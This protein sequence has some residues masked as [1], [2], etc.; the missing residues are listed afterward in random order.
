MPSLSQ[1]LRRLLPWGSRGDAPVV[2]VVRLAGAIGV[3]VGFRPGLSLAAA[4][5]ALE[6]A[7]SWPGAKAVALLINSPGGSPTQS[8]LIHKRIRVLAD[9]KKLPVHAFVEDAA[10]S[11]GYMI[12]CAADDIHADPNSI[13]GS[14]GVVS[15]GFGFHELIARYGIERRLY[16]T[17]EYKAL[18]DPFKPER[19]EDVA[20]LREIQAR[21]FESFKDLVRARRGERLPEEDGDLFT[22][23][24]WAGEDALRMGLV[25][26]IGEA[27]GVLRAKYGEG[28]RPRLVQTVRPGLVAR[29]LRRGGPSME[30]SAAGLL[31]GGSAGLLDPTELMAALEERAL[32]SRLGL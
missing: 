2:P 13:V 4:A 25:D 30:M 21:I 12:A 10:A 7:F 24:F 31:G 28:V 20:R 29:L 17:G 6:R 9:E 19:A 18:L 8:H 26:G 15:G 3:A 11:G 32:W 1:R 22:G 14:I 23:A 5:P 16:T 27:R